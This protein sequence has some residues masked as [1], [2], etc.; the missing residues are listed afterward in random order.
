MTFNRISAIAGV[1]AAALGTASAAQDVQFRML[2]AWDNRFDGTVAVA[3]AYQTCLAETSDGRISVTAS[4]PE[5]IPP[6]QQFDPISRG[7]FDLSFIT[8]IYF[9]GTT[10]VPSAFFALPP[11]SQ[12]WRDKGYWD[13]ADEEMQRFNQKL[14]AFTSGTGASD[15]Y[16]VVLREPVAEGD[17]PLEGRKIRGNKYYEPL[18]VPLGG[19][20]VNLPAGEIYSA[21]EKGVVDGAAYPIAGMQ[22]LKM[23][24]VTSYMLRPRFGNSPFLIAMN[25]DRFNGLSEEDKQL[26]LDCGKKIEESSANELARLSEETIADLKELG[27]EETELPAEAVEQVM[28]G[29]IEGS[30]QT[31]IDGN[32]KTADRVRELQEMAREN[33]DTE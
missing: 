11:D 5:V 24:E 18:V 26:V 15:F 16:Q 1:V 25:L 28:Q 31:A 6:N 30:W 29:L 19:S 27:M 21:L 14:V 2:T 32:A 20:L 4:G 17:M 33:G 13:F 7:I 3:D 23:H 12:L 9:L 10:G 8:P 22:R